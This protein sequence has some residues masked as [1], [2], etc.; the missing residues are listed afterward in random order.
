MPLSILSL[1]LTCTSSKITFVDVRSYGIEGWH[2]G[3]RPHNYCKL[4]KAW[5]FLFMEL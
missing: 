2:L 5:D 1:I 3:E 4:E